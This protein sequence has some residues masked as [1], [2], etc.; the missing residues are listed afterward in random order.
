MNGTE[1]KNNL[2]EIFKEKVTNLELLETYEK[3]K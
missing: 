1:T 2:A 3:V